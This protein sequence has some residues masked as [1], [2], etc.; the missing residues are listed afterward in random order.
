M[1]LCVLVSGCEAGAL[2]KRP[3]CLIEMSV[4]TLCC[5]CLIEMS[6]DTLSS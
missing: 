5:E 3:E 1:D 2:L 6:V 4:E